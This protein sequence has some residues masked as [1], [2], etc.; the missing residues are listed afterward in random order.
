MELD[1]NKIFF[2]T[3]RKHLN[4]CLLHEIIIAM[5]ERIDTDW[6]MHFNFRLSLI[7]TSETFIDTFLDRSS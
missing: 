4:L 7:I 1:I 5:S 6:K 2:W 3:W